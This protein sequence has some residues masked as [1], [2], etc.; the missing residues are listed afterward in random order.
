LALRE[1]LLPG[2]LF[3]MRYLL[4]IL[5]T[6]GLAGCYKTA[7]VQES[8]GGGDA[9]TDTDTDTDADTDSDADSDADTDSGS[10]SDTDTD[11]VCDTDCPDLDWV[12][13]PGGSFQMGST[14][15]EPREEPVHSVTVPTFEMTQTEVTVAQYGACVDVS[16]C[17]VPGSGGTYDNWGVAGRE[18]H[19]VN[20]VDWNQS[21]A[22][23][24]WVGGRLPSESEWEY[25]ASNG[26]SKN[27]YPWGGETATC[28]Y[29][30]MYEGGYGCGTGFTMDVCSKPAGNTSHGLCD[31]S[32][33]VWEW[34]QDWRH[35]NYTGAPAD[36]SAWDDSG[37]Y[38]V[39]R[40]GSFNAGA[41]M[42]RASF[43]G[44]GTPSFQ[45]SYVGF[46][47]GRDAP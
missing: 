11:V 36:G 16:V 47:C 32:G 46:R 18:N 26:A 28:D 7:I 9:D 5:L 4:I 42:L 27:M 23:C 33:N 30:V 34:V 40:G 44:G 15:G 19:P 37:L 25:A 3:S 24:V 22:F 39:K 29:A 12:F 41:D 45:D 6:V 17:T 2:S 13:I 10:D 21:V 8:D 14:T 31:M 43:R 38:R 35:D 20:R 1:C